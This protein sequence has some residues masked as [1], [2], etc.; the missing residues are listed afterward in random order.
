MNRNYARGWREAEASY[1]YYK[2]HKTKEQIEAA[3]QIMINSIADYR[4]AYPEYTQGVVDFCN[5]YLGNR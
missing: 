3:M 5:T 4:A 2:D 1:F